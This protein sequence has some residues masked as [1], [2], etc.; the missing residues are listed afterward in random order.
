IQALH[1]LGRAVN[2]LR[3]HI[4]PHCQSITLWTDSTTSVQWLKK[5]THNEMFV[6]NRLK[7]L[8]QFVIN[9]VAGEDN[10][11]DIASRGCTF[12]ELKTTLFDK[13]FHGP[14]WLSKPQSEWPEI[15]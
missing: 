4:L 8:R 12:N 2:Q 14:S 9:H 7:R 10:P 5:I 3:D 1:L 15:K 6:R 13:W 11:A